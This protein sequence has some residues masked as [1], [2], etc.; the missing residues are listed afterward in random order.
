MGANA[1]HYA[2]SIGTEHD[3]A[4]QIVVRV[5]DLEDSRRTAILPKERASVMPPR[6]API[7][8]TD[9]VVGA[10]MLLDESTL[11]E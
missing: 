5:S 11:I 1:F 8:V 2:Q 4:A 3:S 7:M 10:I 9:L 6:P